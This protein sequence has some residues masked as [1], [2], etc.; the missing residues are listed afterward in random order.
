MAES[1]Q[2]YLRDVQYRFPDRLKARSI[3]HTRYGRGDWFEWLAANIPLPT[4]GLIADVGCGAGSF[5]TNAPQSV[6][7]DL[8]LRLFDISEGMVGAART[9]IAAMQRWHDVEASV[10][11]AVALPMASASVDTTIAVHMLYHLAD[12]ASGL[13]EMA[14][15]TREAG[16]VAVV[17]N[18]ANTMIEL[19]ELARAPFGGERDPR[20]EPLSSEQ[21]LAL[22]QGEFTKVDVVRYDDELRV[23]DPV[24]L[25]GY[26][27][28]L[29]IAD[30][31]GVM[32]KLA[33]AVEEAFRRT[34]G[35]FTIT[36]ASELLIGHK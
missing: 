13:K 19:S 36:K 16:A 33:I 10:S 2:G 35:G 18:P 7:S 27:N 30:K 21:G 29:P 17:L 28:S 6:P 5:W 26:L 14:R 24:D 11:D 9:S 32:E 25:L 23:T 3:L 22:M 8:K 4:G 20:S 1:E 12:P 31:P 15:V 34:E